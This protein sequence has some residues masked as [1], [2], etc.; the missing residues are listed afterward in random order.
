[1]FAKTS[2]WATTSATGHRTAPRSARS[3]TRC[4]SRP[5]DY[6]WSTSDPGPV[7]P[8]PWVR[9]VLDYAT[10]V[11]GVGKIVLDADTRLDPDYLR[12]ALPL[13]DDP[14]VVAIAGWAVTDWETPCKGFVA[15]L[16]TAHRSRIYAF[17]Q[18][19]VKFGQAWRRANAV[20]IVPGSRACTGPR[21][22]RTSTSTRPG[23]SSRTST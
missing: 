3:P 9:D 23:W 22:S 16:F 11:I 12:A 6:H 21:C 2:D 19:L 4:G 14:A 18:R 10:N 13:F 1:V 8:L 5:Y 20:S 15:Q 7:A 17:V